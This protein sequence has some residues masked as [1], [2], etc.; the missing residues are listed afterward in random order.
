MDAHSETLDRV[1][2][3]NR[4]ALE[5]AFDR[6]WWIGFFM[7]LTLYVAIIGLWAR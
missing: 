3:E 2:N 7:W 6:Q 5:R 4:K 1:V